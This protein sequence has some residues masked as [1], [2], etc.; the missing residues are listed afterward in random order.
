M[1]ERLREAEE[2]LGRSRPEMAARQRELEVREKIRVLLYLYP[3]ECVV[4]TSFILYASL[5]LSLSFQDM[6]R[7]L[8]ERDE[9]VCVCVCAC[10]RVHACVCVCANSFLK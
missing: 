10:A 4:G 7:A 5:P 1:E 6:A 3:R 9:E 2:R 8:R